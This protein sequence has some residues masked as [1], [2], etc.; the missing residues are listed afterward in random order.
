MAYTRRK[1]EVGGDFPPAVNWDE[2][3]QQVHGQYSK[4]R[5]VNTKYGAKKV[6]SLVKAKGCKFADSKGRVDFWGTSGLDVQMEQVKIGELIEVIFTGHM[7]TGKGN[8]AK[9]HDVFVL[10]KTPDSNPL[11]IIPPQQEEYIPPQ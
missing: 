4:S 7:D 1:I 6:Y 10:D 3:G 2:V 9:M 5:T 8:P 11:D